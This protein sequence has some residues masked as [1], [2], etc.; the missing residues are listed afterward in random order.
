[1]N[2]SP[3]AKEAMKH[4]RQ[5]L[6]ENSRMPST[7]ELMR[8]MGYKSPL[9]SVMLFNELAAQGYLEKKASGAYKFMKDLIDGISATTVQVPLVGIASCGRPM[10]AEE[11]IEA[12]ISVSTALAKP[13]SRYFLLRADGESM[14]QAGI[15]NGD[16]VL[17][18]Q[19][20][21]ADNGQIVVALVDDD[22]T[23]K[24]FQRRGDVIAL[25]PRSDKT[26]FRPIILDREFQIQG[27]FVAAIP[28]FD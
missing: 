5:F 19:Q 14:N 23:I 21:I 28:S 16:L 2:L 27:V 17:F 15:Q 8:L 18:K 12:M 24:E 11:N 7:R 10:L 22:A 26:E 6:M 1:M 13:G 3:K 25:V 4:I 20:P 9:S